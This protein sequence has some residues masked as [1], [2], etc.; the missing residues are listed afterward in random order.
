[1]YHYYHHHIHPLLNFNPNPKEGCATIKTFFKNLQPIPFL[2]N[3]IELISND[4]RNC[5]ESTITTH[6]QNF[7]PEQVVGI[8]VAVLLLLVPVLVMVLLLPTTTIAANDDARK[9]LCFIYI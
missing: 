5:C 4:D 9:W 8:V 3:V 2:V 7:L 6:I 1:M